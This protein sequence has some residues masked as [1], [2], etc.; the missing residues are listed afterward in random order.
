MH[1]FTKKTLLF[2][3]MLMLALVIS[4]CEGNNEG[5][6]TDPDT[7]GDAGVVEDAAPAGAEQPIAQG[8]AMMLISAMM[9]REVENLAEEQLGHLDDVVIDTATGRVLFAI[10]EHGGFLD[11]GDEDVAIPLTAMA[12]GSENDELLLDLP[13]DTFD[14]YPDMDIEENWGAGVDAAWDDEIGP[15]WN[16]VGYD[17]S[18]VEQADPNMVFLASN[19]T[20]YGVSAFDAPG[21]GN[22]QDMIVDM[23]TGEIAYAVLSFVDA[24]LYGED[25]IL[26]PWDAFE[27]AVTG[28]EL[29]LAD[30]FDMN[31]LNEAPRVNAT[32]LTGVEL[33]EPG[34]D[35]D[36]QAY[37]EEQGFD[38]S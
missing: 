34:W 11:I 9:G 29:V 28:N 35:A 38:I 5:V 6:F 32:N 14:A 23:G 36:V 8:D 33:F 2:S 1:I 27:P 19:L 26:L 31:L 21:L 18:A 24:G 15:F 3:L 22:I 37:W 17:M 16:D 25:W 10:V 20:G 13:E 12:I 30:S 7:V 4:A